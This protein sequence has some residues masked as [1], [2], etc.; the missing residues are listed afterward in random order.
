MER[1]TAA[2]FSFFVWSASYLP[3][4]SS[5]TTTLF[6][7]ERRQ[8]LNDVKMWSFTNTG[9][10]L[11][12][13][14]ERHS[15]PFKKKGKTGFFWLCESRETKCCVWQILHYLGRL[16]TLSSF[17]LCVHFSQW[18]MCL[19]ANRA[20]DP[21][22]SGHLRRDELYKSL[23][24]SAGSVFT[25]SCCVAC[26]WVVGSECFQRWQKCPAEFYAHLYKMM[27]KEQEQE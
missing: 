11:A 3:T 17:F 25:R 22:T 12:A 18:C 20:G 15:T 23:W 7:S 2:L 9:Y 26:V 1:V 8:D 4:F 19:F 27:Q 6:H 21:I 5:C 13:H 16:T 14:G 24:L 10:F